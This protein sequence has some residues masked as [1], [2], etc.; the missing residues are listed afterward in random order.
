MRQERR[1]KVVPAR[2]ARMP[3]AAAAQHKLGTVRDRVVNERLELV[4]ARVRDHR[5]AVDAVAPG[6]PAEARL[7]ERAAAAEHRDAQAHELCKCIACVFRH[8]EALDADAVLA[9]SLETST[10]DCVSG[11]TRTRDGATYTWMQRMPGPSRGG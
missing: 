1:R 4:K 8:E 6:A 10:H 7:V 2:P 11:E 3:N 9:H 5:A